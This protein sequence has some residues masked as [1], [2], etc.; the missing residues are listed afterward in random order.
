VQICRSLH[1]TLTWQ[2]ALGSFSLLP[3][4]RIT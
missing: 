3:K 2:K 4:A 1:T